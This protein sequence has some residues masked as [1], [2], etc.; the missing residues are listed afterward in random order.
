LGT[1]ARLRIRAIGGRGGPGWCWAVR[2]AVV[3]GVH[4]AGA[5]CRKGRRSWSEPRC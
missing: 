4:S 3:L 2:R 1:I 5:R